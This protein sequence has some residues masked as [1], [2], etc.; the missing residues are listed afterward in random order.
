[1]RY[2]LQTA[3]FTAILMVS[4]R[5][6]A[7]PVSQFD[8]A[9]EMARKDYEAAMAKIAAVRKADQMEC[10][11]QAGPALKACTIQTDSKRTASEKDA[12]L[13]LARAREQHPASKE[14]Q[15]KAAEAGKRKAKTQYGVAKARIRSDRN[16]ANAECSKLKNAEERQCK[17]SVSARY[18]IANDFASSVYARALATAQA[19]VDH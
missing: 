9:Q 12:T 2:P 6:I 5:T 17:K 19:T 15:E 8:A 4:V 13:L 7:A 11:K 16:L 3:L 14:D 10:A 1:V 18:T